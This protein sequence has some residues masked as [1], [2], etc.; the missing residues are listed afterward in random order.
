MTG[1]RMN[2]GKKQKKK[3]NK[4]KGE[5]ELL[6]LAGELFSTRGYCNTSMRD[7]ANAYGCQTA[8]IYNFFATKE[9]LLYRFLAEMHKELENVISTIAG[10]TTLNPVEKLELLIRKQLEFA[11]GPGRSLK[12][13]IDSGLADL[14][15]PKRREIIK[16]RDSYDQTLRRMIRDCIDVGEFAEIDVKL[17]A[18]MIPSMILRTRVWFSEKGQMSKNE[19]ADFIIQF[20]LNG[21]RKR[22]D[23]SS[24]D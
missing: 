7:I 23:S 18:I 9:E 1:N 16:L 20:V 4:G 12:W 21:L 6:K 19:V 10:N 14:S 13:I 17:A 3:Q 8:N 2:N 22:G 24:K 11:L 5:V 15:E